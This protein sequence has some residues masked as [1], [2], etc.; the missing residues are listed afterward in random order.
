MKTLKMEKDIHK[1]ATEIFA[2]F[3]IKYL[4]QLPDIE[5]N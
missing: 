4:E 3:Y 5:N 2:K 1:T